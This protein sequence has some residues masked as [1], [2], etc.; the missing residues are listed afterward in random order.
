MKT[1]CWSRDVEL[2]VLP[3]KNGLMDREA[4]ASEMEKGDVAALLIAT[5][6]FFGLVED[7]TGLADTLHKTK[8]KLI[9][10]TDLLALGTIKAP[11][12]LG[13]D[14]VVGD[15]QSVGN[16]MNFGGPSFGFMAVTKKLMRKMPGRVVG[17]TKDSAGKDCYVLT[18]QAR[19][20]HIRREKA[21]SNIC[22]NQNL[23]IV[24]AAIYMSLMG[25]RGFTEVNRQICS[26][27]AYAVNELVKTG[28]FHVE[29]PGAC[30]YREV[31]LRCDE[32]V[33]A[34]NARLLE[35]GI[36]GGYDMEKEFPGMKN[37]WLLAVTEQRTREE[38]DRL[39]EIAAGGDK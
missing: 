34:I 8:A 2:V 23:C 39:V 20:Q 11:G 17:L 27:L 3:S 28:K 32:S 38:I 13:A 16:A 26:K 33:E 1:Y 31:V 22:S 35:A 4:F 18:L 7:L 19:E 29:F 5:P 15:G 9:V 36:L 6:N 10:Y 30:S 37:C 12:E 14:F 24:E 25:P 21:M